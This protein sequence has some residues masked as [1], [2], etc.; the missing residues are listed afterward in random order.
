ME[1]TT[2]SD[3]REHPLTVMVEKDLKKRIDTVRGHEPRSGFIR[4]MIIF[5]L[6]YCGARTGAEF[7]VIDFDPKDIIE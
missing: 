4:R 7:Q 1:E 2:N 6:D 3:I 5:G